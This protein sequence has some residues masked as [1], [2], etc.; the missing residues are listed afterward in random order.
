MGAK[1]V[2]DYRDAMPDQY[3]SKYGL[4]W[5]HPLILLLR[6]RQE[7]SPRSHAEVGAG[8]RGRIV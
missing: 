1:L 7:T 2:F 5:N 4:G 3:V 8:D 6:G